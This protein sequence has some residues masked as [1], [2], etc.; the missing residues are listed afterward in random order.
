MQVLSYG[1]NKEKI[2]NNLTN[3]KREK[4]DNKDSKKKSGIVSKNT[5]PSKGLKESRENSKSKKTIRNVHKKKT[6]Q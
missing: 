5:Y 6:K 1:K 4:T 2:V 3:K